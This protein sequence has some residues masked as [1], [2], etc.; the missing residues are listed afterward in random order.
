VPGKQDFP[1]TRLQIGRDAKVSERSKSSLQVY[2]QHSFRV[3]H[4]VGKS[5]ISRC[6]LQETI[7]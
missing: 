6:E 2:Q 3:G 5:M 4:A 7:R 1:S